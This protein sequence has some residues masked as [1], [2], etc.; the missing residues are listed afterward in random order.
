VREVL[1]QRALIR[2]L[3]EIL[4]CGKAMLG[5]WSRYLDAREKDLQTPQ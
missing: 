5:A 1:L 3:H 4:A 2:S